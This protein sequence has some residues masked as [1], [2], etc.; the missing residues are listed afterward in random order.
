M[1]K[2]MTKG[3]ADN[4]MRVMKAIFNKTKHFLHHYRDDSTIDCWSE[5]NYQVSAAWE[6]KCRSHEKDT[7]D[8][9]YLSFR[10]YCHLMYWD[11]IQGLPAFFVAEFKDGEI[12]IVR[13]KDI[14]RVDY[15]I[16]GRQDRKAQN[17]REPF[18]LVPLLSMTPLERFDIG[19]Y[20][21]S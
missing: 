7:Y 20:I 1:P 12:F 17:D 5:F 10:K 16:S 21:V 3:D 11:D 2:F 4:E 18:L 13:V 8:S 14:P 6:I 9:L 19:K 15:K